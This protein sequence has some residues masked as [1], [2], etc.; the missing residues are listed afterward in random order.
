MN[1]LEVATQTNFPPIAVFWDLE[2][3]RIPKS[4][5]VASIVQK[6]RNNIFSRYIEEDIF[7][8]CDVLK[9]KKNLLLILSYCVTVQ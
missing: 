4:K 6:L 3:V 8:V 7:I 9:K 1:K 2:N 5:S